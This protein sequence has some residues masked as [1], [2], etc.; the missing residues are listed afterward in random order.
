MK[1]IQDIDINGKTVILRCDFNVPLKDGQV[2]DDSKIIKSLKTIKYIIEHNAK[3]VLLSHLGRVKAES[4]KIGKSLKVV[5]DYLKIQLNKE[6]IFFDK[7]RDMNL[8]DAIADVLPI[9][10]FKRKYI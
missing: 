2:D 7:T 10:E 9:I 8:E 5:A 1:N 3:V 6:V 4:D